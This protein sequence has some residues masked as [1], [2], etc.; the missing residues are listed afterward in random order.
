MYGKDLIHE[1][2]KEL[3]GDF[4]DVIVALMMTPPEYDVWQLHNAMKVLLSSFLFFDFFSIFPNK[5][6]FF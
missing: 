4:E 6:S 5:F 3:H 1:L 2:K